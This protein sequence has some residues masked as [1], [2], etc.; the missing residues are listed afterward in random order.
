MQM[1]PLDALWDTKFYTYQSHWPLLIVWP[2]SLLI[3][4]S[5][6]S[7]LQETSKN[8]NLCYTFAFTWST[9]NAYKSPRFSVLCGP[10]CILISPRTVSPQ[11]VVINYQNITKGPRR[12]IISPFLVIDDNTTHFIQEKFWFSNLPHTLGI[13][14]ILEMSF[15]RL[16]LI[17]SSVREIDKSQQNSE[18][19][20]SSPYMCAWYF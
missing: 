8:K 9:T 2:Y 17:W 7:K 19:R 20:N 11:I 15:V 1:Q 13:R 5:I 6:F 14:R 18:C 4:S 3:W 10:T 12:F 16:I